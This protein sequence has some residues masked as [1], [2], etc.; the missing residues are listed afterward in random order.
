MAGP[1]EEPGL[2][3]WLAE[4]GWILVAAL[5]GLVWKMLDTRIKKVEETAEAAMPRAETD[6][7]TDERRQD[8]ARMKNQ[9]EKL[10]EKNEQTKDLINAK[11]DGLQRDVHG[12]IAGLRHDIDDKFD[13]IMT[14]INTRR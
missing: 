3:A 5:V 10:F 12:Q 11:V 6:R 2:W 13:R 4:K 7:R 14:A 1:G 9:I 8:T